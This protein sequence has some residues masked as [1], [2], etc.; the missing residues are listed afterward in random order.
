METAGNIQQLVSDH[1]QLLSSAIDLVT[2]AREEWT[3]YSS[4][5]GK[6]NVEANTIV[7]MIT[8]LKFGIRILRKS[9]TIVHFSN[10]CL[11]NFTIYMYIAKFFL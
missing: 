9:D 5:L 3:E 7:R 1:N 10:S 4:K 11:L 8:L 2:T 6:D